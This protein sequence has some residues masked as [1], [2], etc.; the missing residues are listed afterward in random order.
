MS[1]DSK[2]PGELI[3]RNLLKA[4]SKNIMDTNARQNSPTQSVGKIRRNL[5]LLAAII[6]C[7]LFQ[8]CAAPQKTKQVAVNSPTDDRGFEG[9]AK[10]FERPP[11]FGSRFNDD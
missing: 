5:L 1:I 4:E 3:H 2:V 6:V 10:R 8:S 11:P 9:G 7:G